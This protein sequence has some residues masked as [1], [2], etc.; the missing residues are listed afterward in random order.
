MNFYPGES[1][2]ITVSV[3]FGMLDSYNIK[4]NQPIQQDKYGLVWNGI[5]MEGVSTMDKSMDSNILSA[6]IK[7]DHL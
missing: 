1:S 7:K 4:E 3:L 6:L 2:S 5:S